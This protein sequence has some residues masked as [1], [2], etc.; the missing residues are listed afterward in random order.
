MI[1][2]DL[3][4][5][6]NVGK[7]SL[8]LRKLMAEHLEKMGIDGDDLLKNIGIG[9]VGV[10][11]IAKKSVDAFKYVHLNG[12]WGK[13]ISIADFFNLNE[14]DLKEPKIY[15]CDFDTPMDGLHSSDLTQDQIDR[16]LA[17]LNE[18]ES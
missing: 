9:S 17:I 1:K 12:E 2:K 16:V 5:W 10:I 3:K 8:K 15:P 6:V 4:L 14:A 7:N 18:G 13:E 11:A